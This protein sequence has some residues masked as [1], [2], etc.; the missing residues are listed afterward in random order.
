MY[1]V[2]I[3]YMVGYVVSLFTIFLYN[4]LSKKYFKSVTLELGLMY[5]LFSWVMVIVSIIAILSRL[6]GY[7]GIGC[8]KACIKICGDNFMYKLKNKFE[9]K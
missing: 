7:V 6:V 4:L 5:S 9:C 1:D 3:W 2:I 8:R